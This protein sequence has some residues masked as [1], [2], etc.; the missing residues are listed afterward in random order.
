MSALCPGTTKTNFFEREGARIPPG[1][2]SADKVAKIAFRGLMNNKEIIVP[3]LR[4]RLLQVFPLKI[5][6]FFIAKVK[7]KD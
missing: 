3:G 1:A 7:D 6:M 5:K 4:N 2:M